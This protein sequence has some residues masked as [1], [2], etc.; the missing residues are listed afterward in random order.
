MQFVN[1]L[2]E[3]LRR[4]EPNFGGWIQ[5]PHPSVAEIM[6]ETGFDWVTFD[7]EHGSMGIETVQAMMQAMRNSSAVPLVRLPMNDPVWIRDV[8]DAGAMGV[9]VPLVNTAQ[10]AADAVKYVKYPPAGIRGIG[11]A[12]AHHYGPAF[13]DYVDQANDITIV[14]AQIEH[15][16]GVENIE[17]ILDTEGIDG[18]FVGPYDLTGSMGLLG[19]LDHPKVVEAL[20][21]VVAM[22]RKK[23][24]PAGTHVVPVDPDEVS[25][26]LEQ[27]FTMIA[28]SIDGLMII[29]GCKRLMDAA[30]RA[31]TDQQQVGLTPK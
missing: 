29:D 19:Q 17:A 6:C 30:K 21:D 15:I 24:K 28:M 10:E 9:I 20:D 27:G 13:K 7:A 22:A 8:M 26:R 2:K 18:I 4:N 5:I 31:L 14:I 12:R 3:K 11:I 1:P 23:N 25:L 16:K